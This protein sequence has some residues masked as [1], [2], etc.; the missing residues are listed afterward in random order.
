[1][2]KEN[3]I[4]ESLN[5]LK[6]NSPYKVPEG[7][8]DNLPGIIKENVKQDS[9]PQKAK[10]IQILKPWMSLAAGFLFIVVIYVTFIPEKTT[11]QVATTSADLFEEYFESIDPIASQLSEYD[12]ASYLSDEDINE[13]FSK[14]MEQT[15]ISTLTAEEI[16]DLILF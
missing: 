16:E 9:L 3:D 5:V 8:F 6:G 12:L 15:D 4:L 11:I 2:N 10:I 1:M 7:Y 13:A 14:P